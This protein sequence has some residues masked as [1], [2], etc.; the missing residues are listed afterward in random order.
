[1]R[2]M[3]PVILLAAMLLTTSSCRT[4]CY[5]PEVIATDDG[6]V[7]HWVCLQ[8]ETKFTADVEAF[9]GSTETWPGPGYR[10]TM[11]ASDGR[12]TDSFVLIAFLF[13]AAGTTFVGY[14]L[15]EQQPGYRLPYVLAQP[16]HYVAGIDHRGD[17]LRVRLPRKPIAWVPIGQWLDEEAAPG[18]AGLKRYGE[19]KEGIVYTNKIE[20][21][22]ALCERYGGGPDFWGELCFNFHR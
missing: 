9:T 1:M 3:L 21:V 16:V 19:M 17:A 11:N 2:R 10:V 5:G 4:P 8:G 13:K 6:L 14:Q 22:V 7:G 18:E 15:A 12:N 20:R